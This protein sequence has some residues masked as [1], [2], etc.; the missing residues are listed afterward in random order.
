MNR[1]KLAWTEAEMRTVKVRF[2]DGVPDE[3]IA[4]ELGR[5]AESIKIRR[6]KMN[7]KY[8]PGRK[9]KNQTG[10]TSINF[11]QPRTKKPRKVEQ[12]QYREVSILWGMFKFKK[13]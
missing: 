7:L 10:Q 5:T 1:E 9:P 3:Q 6:A 8:R 12:V 4:Q 13:S 2:E 11:T